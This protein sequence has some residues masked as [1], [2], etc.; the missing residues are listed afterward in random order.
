MLASMREM[1]VAEQRYQAVLDVIAE[2]RTVVEVAGQSR[3]NRRTVHRWLAKY[4][5][6]GLEGVPDRSHRPDR[7]PHQMPAEIEVMVL[8]LRR[9]HRC[10]GAR[11]LVIEL[12]RK[13]ITP[14]PSESAVY[15]CLVRAGVI[16]PVKRQRRKEMWKRCE[17]AGAMGR[18]TWWAA[19][20][21]LTARQPRH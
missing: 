1:S 16:D 20:C 9:T 21:S 3:V 18:W 19:F 15:R 12:V 2:G 13:G 5:A 4:A 14:L 6:E 7:C 10:W 11:R 8:E 17:R